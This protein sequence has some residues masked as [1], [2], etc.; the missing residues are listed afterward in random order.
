MCQHPCNR[1]ESAGVNVW[2]ACREPMKMRL[3]HDIS[4]LTTATQAC[5]LASVEVAEPVQQNSRGR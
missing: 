3:E 4:R 1:R 5:A 2:Q